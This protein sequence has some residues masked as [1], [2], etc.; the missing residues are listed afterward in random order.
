MSSSAQQEALG[1][2]K[3]GFTCKIH[4]LTDALGLPVR[5]LLTPGQD[6]DISQAP[7]LV[8]GFGEVQALLADKGYDSDAFVEGLTEQGI[9]AVI[10][11]R[12]NRKS[13][14]ECDW[15]LYK[16]RHSIECMFGKL[17]HYRRAFSRFE[18]KA[19]NYLGMLSLASVM[20]WL[21]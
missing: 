21:R 20:L 15:H 7:N 6:S 11:P 17:K 14:R 1:R 12:A 16:E 19:I 13:P 5:L 10:P 9:I 3:G 8:E 2:S 18:K 4:A